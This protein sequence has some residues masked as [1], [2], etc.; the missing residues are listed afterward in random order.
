M[1]KHREFDC[2]HG[3]KIVLTIFFKAY[4]KF[5]SNKITIHKVFVRS[6]RDKHGG[7]Q[8]F[9]KNYNMIRTYRVND[10]LTSRECHEQ[11]TECQNR[12]EVTLRRGLR[13]QNIGSEFN[14]RHLGK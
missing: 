9:K 1:T 3:R 13:L 7:G 11:Q 12:K 6:P 8:I 10:T 4:T 14:I 5:Y 2:K